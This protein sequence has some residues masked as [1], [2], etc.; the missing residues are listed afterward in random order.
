MAGIVVPLDGWGRSS[1][2]ALAYDEGSVS[3][4]ATGSI[5]TT[6]ISAGAS[7]S[8]TGVAGTTTLASVLVTGDKSGEV[9]GNAATGAVGTVTTVAEANAAVTGVAGTSAL[10][11]ESVTA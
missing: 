6:T 7:A 4:S 11:S 5:G 2:N 10:G 3:V 1:W 8:V 9:L